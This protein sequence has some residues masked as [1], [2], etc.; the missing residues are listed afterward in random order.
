MNVPYVYKLL[1]LRG[2]RSR[3]QP[4]ESKPTDNSSERSSGGL[5]YGVEAGP[6]LVGRTMALFAQFGVALGFNNRDNDPSSLLFYSSTTVLALEL[7]DNRLDLVLQFNLV[8]LLK[9]TI[10]L[11]DPP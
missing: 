3:R 10:Y 8:F 7:L 1:P 6:A 9:V 4:L 5:P 11:Q 2:T